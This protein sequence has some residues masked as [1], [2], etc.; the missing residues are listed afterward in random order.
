MATIFLPFPLLGGFLI[1]S[2]NPDQLSLLH[3]DLG[4]RRYLLDL[5]GVWCELGMTTMI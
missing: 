5:K 4:E 3:L 1:T 2:L